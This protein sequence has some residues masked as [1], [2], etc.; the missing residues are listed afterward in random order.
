MFDKTRLK[1]QLELCDPTVII[2]GYTSSILESIMDCKNKHDSSNL[3]YHIS[4]NGHDV[5]VIN[6][7]H[8]ANRYPDL[9]NYYGLMG[10]YHTALNDKEFINEKE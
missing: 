10:I 2:C 8:P 3:S 7:W 6:Y 1:R 5:L 4:S 9:M